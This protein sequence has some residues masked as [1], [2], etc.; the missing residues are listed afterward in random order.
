[1]EEYVGSVMQS[2]RD[3]NESGSVVDKD[4]NDAVD[5]VDSTDQPSRTSQFFKNISS[6]FTFK[7]EEDQIE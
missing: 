2:E 6:I 7:K 1:M 3:A 5:A 4:I